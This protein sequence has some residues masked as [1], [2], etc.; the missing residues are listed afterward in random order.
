MYE[1]P[2]RNAGNG[3]LH[4]AGRLLMFG[5]LMGLLMGGVAV[6]GMAAGGEED[7]ENLVYVPPGKK[8]GNKQPV[9]TPPVA[10][11]PEQ[12]E[13]N[14]TPDASPVA[15]QPAPDPEPVLE[16]QAPQ[17][18]DQGS[19]QSSQDPGQDQDPQNPDQ[20]DSGQDPQNPGQDQQDSG[21]DN[22][23]VVEVPPADTPDPQ[24]APEPVS[25]TDGPDQG[26]V[27]D[28]TDAG[29]VI[30]VREG[31]VATLDPGAEANGIS[32]L[33][34]I[35]GPAHGNVTVNPDNTF[36]LVLTG[37]DHEGALSFSY[38]ATYEDGSSEI[39]TQDL[40]VRSVRQQG[41]WG[42]GDAFMMRTDEDGDIVVETGENHRKVYISE[43]ESALSKRDI[44][45]LEGMEFEDVTFEWLKAHPEY[46]ST[47]EMALNQWAGTELWTNLQLE[48]DTPNSH[49]ALFERGYTYESTKNLLVRGM[50]GEDELHPV[51]IT[52]YGEGEAPVL[53]A[54]TSAFNEPISNVVISDVNFKDGLNVIYGENLLLDG[55]TMD[56][57]RLLSVQHVDGFTLRDSNILDIAHEAPQDGRDEWWQH[58]DRMQGFYIK[59]STGV[60]IENNLFDHNGWADDYRED[61][62]G[63]G[64]QPPSQY[65]QNVYIQHNNLDVTFRDNISMRAASFGA[66]VRPG[67]FIEDNVFID[68]N[69][70]LSFLGG[71]QN[72]DG[73][74]TGNFSLVTGNVTTSGAHKE[75]PYTGALTQGMHNAGQLSTIHENIVAH[76]A[77]PN[78]PDELDY[79]YW[80]HDALIEERPAYYDDT[81]TYNWD[82]RRTFEQGDTNDKNTQNVNTAIAD[83]TTIQLYAAALLDKPDATI[84][85]LA[86][87]LRK[88]LGSALPGQT[89]AD[90]IAAY[91]REGFGVGVED[92]GAGAQ[93]FTFVPN[94]LGGGIRWDNRLNWDQDTLP[95][96]DDGDSVRLAGNWVNYGGTTVIDQ[97]DFGSGGR[98]HVGHGY[99]SVEGEM[100]AGES[101]AMLSVDGA[102]QFWT[103]GY[104][105]DDLLD[106]D[107]RG[108]RFANTG[109]FSGNVDLTIT[110]GQAILASQGGNFDLGGASRLVIGGE[111]TRTGFDGTDG[112]TAVLR[113][114]DGAVLGF[115]AQDGS[116]GTISEFRSGFYGTQD[117]NIQ[118]GVNL[119]MANLHLDLSGLQNAGGEYT[120]IEADEIIGGFG[121]IRVHGLRSDQKAEI[122]VDYE[123]DKVT[124]N[125]TG[126]S[127]DVSYDAIGDADDAQAAADLWAALTDGQPVYDEAAPALETTD[128]ELLD[129]SEAA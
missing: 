47:P 114:E 62:S 44:A 2:R 93:T 87:H 41:G 115:S 19:E 98:L 95:G 72:D 111:N 82:S 75:A 56:G 39:L 14:E 123:T 15:E 121:E 40:N 51:Y 8:P 74:L 99:L 64:G 13:Q 108:G 102:G 80:N 31:R 1:F 96:M 118:S 50:Q 113:F 125:L 63:E 68:N 46:G 117:T 28:A 110:D 73:T 106:I 84:A 22:P 25:Q 122:T 90:L 9:Q 21:Q 6:A 81:I 23:V 30:E 17:V 126:G 83:Q 60:L 92:P 109:D 7:E 105:D 26:S 91:F 4:T 66:Q 88:D 16:A 24:P 85:D 48:N 61:L 32:A 100:T 35:D 34:I 86:D 54:H 36:A 12:A 70:A 128:E 53:T 119:G 127:G 94:D 5:A 124:L 45:A 120:L 38:E 65:S 27:L 3:P 107:V 29:S 52:S 43:S 10:D 37:T 77:D 103:D 76:L 33:R 67:G 89:D 78:N 71:E 112:D 49:W 104:T 116:L 97:F 55:V 59:S 20:Q 18:P 129:I 58:S 11:Q 101:G 57:T 69:A 79:K 42:E